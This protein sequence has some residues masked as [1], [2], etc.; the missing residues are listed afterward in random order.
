[1]LRKRGWG[2]LPGRYSIGR[3]CPV[4]GLGV[5]LGSY[6]CLEGA[7]LLL[8]AALDLPLNFHVL[9]ID[10][11]VCRSLDEFDSRADLLVKDVLPTFHLMNLFVLS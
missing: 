2:G 6:L 4:G 9:L 8:E 10:R 5:V 11:F 1:M 7:L 3:G